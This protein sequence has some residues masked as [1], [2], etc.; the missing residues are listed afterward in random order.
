MPNKNNLPVREYLK[1]RAQRLTY[2]EPEGIYESMHNTAFVLDR[3]VMLR[4]LGYDGSD[5]NLCAY[6]A[7]ICADKCKTDLSHVPSSEF[8]EYMDCDCPVAVLFFVAAGA[9]E[10][11]EKLKRFEDTEEAARAGEGA[12]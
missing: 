2:D 5:I 6:C 8:G 11:R 10:M 3:E 7:S 4:G 9:A 12:E 1:Q